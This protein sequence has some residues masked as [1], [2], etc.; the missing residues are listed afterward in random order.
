[1]S[2]M[3][4]LRL[5]PLLG[6]VALLVASGALVGCDACEDVHCAPCTLIDNVMVVLDTRSQPSG[7]SQAEIKDAYIVRY[8]RPGFAAPLDTLPTGLCQSGVSCK[9]NLQEYPIPGAQGAQFAQHF[10]DFNYRVVLPKASRTY[11]ISDI[12]VQTNPPGEGCCNCGSNLRRRLMLDG[13]P[14]QDVGKGSG[15]C[16]LLSR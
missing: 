13:V 7:F 3:K 10:A 6:S 5:M 14:V 2:A 11:S 16:I 4:N 1:M 12:D 9:F 8:A 15:N